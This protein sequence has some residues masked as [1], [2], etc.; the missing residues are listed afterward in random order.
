VPFCEFFDGLGAHN[1]SPGFDESVDYFI[2][3]VKL[4][5]GISSFGALALHFSRIAFIAR[6]GFAGQL[7]QALRKSSRS[8]AHC[9]Y[10]EANQIIKI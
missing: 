1:L 4:R 3:S 8:Y 7:I 6:C 5:R 10:R 2:T 9:N